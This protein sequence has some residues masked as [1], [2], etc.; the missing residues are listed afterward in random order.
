M[1]RPRR[2]SV[3]TK[4][5]RTSVRRAQTFVLGAECTLADARKL[6]A[7]L[8]KLVS[9]RTPVRID[10]GKVRRIDTASVQILTAFVRD[11]RAAGRPVEWLA[12]ASPL[13]DAVR[14]LGLDATFELP[15]G[16]EAGS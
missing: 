7:R 13:I 8:K 9:S 10:A 3:A 4:K 5:R 12:V 15:A 1:N 16:Q 14:L 6:Y 2:A 11:R